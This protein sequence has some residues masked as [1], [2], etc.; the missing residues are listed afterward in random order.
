MAITV[1]T[2]NITVAS[3]VANASSPQTFSH[4]CGANVKLLVVPI[5][6][7]DASATDGVVSAVT[8]D[9]APL[10]SATLYYDALCDG[11]VSIWWLPRPNTGASSTVSVTFGGAVTDFE[12]AAVGVNGT[13]GSYTLDAAGTPQTGTTG[14]LVISWN[15][16]S[17]DSISFACGLDD[18]P[19]LAK[20]TPQETEIYTVDV[21]DVVSAEYAIRSASGSQTMTIA[22]ADGDED[23]VIVGAGF[24]EIEYLPFR[25]E[26]KLTTLPITH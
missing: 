24:S 14:N 6:I 11:H 20:V 8:Y 15:A 3:P 5:T 4:T 16:N 18:Q 10:S 12:A 23:W 21:G 26:G 7:Y 19:V 17:Q 25:F 22:D 1:D 13:L 9:G 2:G